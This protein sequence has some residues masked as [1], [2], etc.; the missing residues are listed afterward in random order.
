M[1]AALAYLPVSIAPSA[2]WITKDQIISGAGVS[3]RWI[4]MLTTRQVLITRELSVR[5]RNG[6]PVREYLIS[7]LPDYLR[8]KL[9]PAAPAPPPIPAASPLQPLFASLPAEPPVRVKV[10]A[11]HQAEVARC[12][13]LIQPL[14]DFAQDRGRYA[15]LRLQDGRAVTSVDMLA[16]HIAETETA[17]GRPVSGRTLTRWV[18]AWKRD[19][20]IALAP[21]VRT[22]KGRSRWATDNRVMADLAAW[23]AIGD[24]NQPPQSVMV[25]WE[26]VCAYADENGIDAPSYETI[27]SF[28]G[29]RNEVSASMKSL[30][31]RGK[32]GYEKVFAGYLQRGYTEPANQIWI[33]DHM[34]ADVLVQDDVFE[35]DLKHCRIQMTTII[36]Y[37]SRLVVGVSWCRNGSSHSIKRALLPAI[38]QYGPPAIF[39]IDNGKDY[40]KVGG[41]SELLRAR[42]FAGE[43]V[44]KLRGSVLNRLGIEAKYCKPYHPQAKHIEKYH[45]FYHARVD[46]TFPTYTS[47]ATHLR[48]D[49]TVE[50]LVEHKKL[51]AIDD[52]RSSKMPLASE[53]IA[54]AEAWI[55]GEYNHRPH[56]GEGMSGRSPAEC[57]QQELNPAQK[58]SPAFEE[59]AA[60]M[61][62]HTL[63]KVRNGAVEIDGTRFVAAYDD[64]QATARMHELSGADG[65]VDVAYD[66]LN[67]ERAVV[68]DLDGRPLC[69]L[70]AQGLTRFSDDDETRAEIAGMEQQRGMMLKATRQSIRDLSARVNDAGHKPLVA[71]LRAQAQLPEISSIIHKPRKTASGETAAPSAPAY[72]ADTIERFLRRRANANS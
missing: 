66:P 40:R 33:S 9:Q 55:F 45:G 5:G 49:E 62:E 22:D 58:P 7:S 61:A 70:I 56:E 42:E 18:A 47:G 46:R 72:V 10:P 69:K 67:M 12:K 19:G 64:M 8:A 34:L 32:R 65:K 39:Y 48:R 15:A 43:E 51:V 41:K 13:A 59:L 11:E 50:I 20:D 25:A 3:A 44:D 2:D 31:T 52:T 37:R 38:L 30:Q 53:Y 17:A 28:L 54:M 63:R 57:F 29:N 21:K 23:I 6:R 1:S 36:D 4:E 16:L 71:Q 35:K 68:L 26:Q 14:L 27:R 60:L 24:A